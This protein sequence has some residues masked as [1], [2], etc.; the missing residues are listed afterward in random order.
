MY[1]QIED[2]LDAIVV[3]PLARGPDGWYQDEGL[4]DTLEVWADAL[5]TFDIDRE[6]VYVGGY[7][8][9]GFGT[10]R[11]ATMMPDAFAS[12]F[13]IVGPPSDGIWA[14]PAAPTGGEDNPTFTYPQL[15][16][17]RHVPFWITQGVEDEL[18][19]FTGVVTQALRFGELGHEYRFALH[20]VGDHFAFVFIDEWSREI[21]W[22]ASHPT[23]VTDPHRVTFDVRPASWASAGDPTILGHVSTLI[24]EV[25]AR[26]DGAYWIDDVVVAEGDDVTGEIDLS[27][28]GIAS[29]QTGVSTVMGP[30]IDGPGPHVLTGQ[31]KVFEPGTVSDT[32]TGTLSGVTALTVD[33]GRAGLSDAPSVE[34]S[35]DG[36]ATITFERDGIVVGSV[37]V[38]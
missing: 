4:V 12:A 1:E 28:G 22:L 27:S 5:A 38:G 10:Y 19:P 7:S 3:T 6:R 8:M 35:S 25:G 2:G 33:V 34:V 30:G 37:S 16:S 32:L 23:R 17:A 13:S 14:Y 31:D 15:E 21:G 29:R 9:G 20:P 11:L 26:L 36:P 18:V 24:A